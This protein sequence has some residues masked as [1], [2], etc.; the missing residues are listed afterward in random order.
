[1]PKKSQ[2]R[3]GPPYPNGCLLVA[4]LG[5]DGKVTGRV[6][7]VAPDD[8]ELVFLRYKVFGSW[9]EYYEFAEVSYVRLKAKCECGWTCEDIYNTFDP[10]DLG[11]ITKKMVKAH[12]QNKP[13]CKKE[14]VILQV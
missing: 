11:Y 2:Y 14:V 12:F 8:V 13:K 1:M 7:A 6:N 9:I 10:N 3:M 4:E 5:K